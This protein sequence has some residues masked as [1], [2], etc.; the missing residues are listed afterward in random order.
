MV[1]PLRSS[2]WYR[3][4]DLKPR[5]R[6]HARIHRQRHR[7]QLWYVLQDRQNGQFHRLSPL[8]HHIVCLMDGRRTIDQIWEMM[9]ERYG[10]DQPTQDETIRLLAQVHAADLLIGDVPPDM[11][12]LAHRADRHSR[13]SFVQNIRNPLA[14][15]IPLIDPE[16]FLAATAPL[17]RLLFSW[18]GF[19]FWLAT[20]AIGLALAGMRWTALTH[21]V[22]DRVLS[23][24]NIVLLLLVYPLVKALHEIGHGMATARWGGEVHELGVML[25]VLMPVPYVDASAS[26]AF[27]EKRR[28]II[29]G[30]AGIMVEMFLAAVAMMVWALVEKGFV[31]AA[32]FDVMLIG[33]ASTLL[34][35]GNPLLRFDG[36]YIL[37]DL[38]EIPN[39]GA[40]ANAYALYLLQRY[41]F[42]LAHLPSPATSP[43]EARWLL[44]YA[45]ASFL[46]RMTV[47]FGIALFIGSRFF[48]LGILLALW[49]IVTGVA[50]PL[51]KGF[52]RLLTDPQLRSVR[53]R[54][55]LVSGLAT[56]ALVV[57]ATI[58]PV[59]YATMAQGVVVA[60]E[61]STLRVRADG[62]VIDALLAEDLYVE[63]GTRVATLA[64]PTLAGETA[65]LEAQTEAYRL[66][67]EAVAN[68]DLV[69]ANIFREELRRLE[70][71]LAL[72]RR[73]MADLSILAE[74]SGRLIL[75]RA[76]DLP[77]KFLKKGDLLG[78]VIAEGD[79]VVR[80]VVPQSD[81]DLARSRTMKVEIRFVGRVDRVI[82]AVVAREAP[83]ALD[84]L[85]SLALSK[86][87]GGDIA[88]D[89]TKTDAPRALETQFHLDLHVAPQEERMNIGER[90]YVRFD[91]GAEP[92]AW[93]LWR[94]ARQLLLRQFGV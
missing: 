25:L 39:L 38:I 76:S 17:G 66:R 70:G 58:V 73:R 18:W 41:A 2:S 53:G 93:R 91:H 5:L 6:S 34:V 24:E 92:V 27:Q 71:A 51:A 82:P 88:I 4:A 35:N 30:A 89:P 80:V 20:I 37:A 85:P 69:Q 44:A 90:V 31:R 23:S 49:G 63:A 43:G 26:A 45:A 21:N 15:R 59:P 7:G 13:R 48:I 72:N 3:V 22:A 64:D 33:S 56:A 83:A 40:R 68:S 14:I 60:P 32:A 8:A 57:L 28:R 84:E 54:A 81:I 77:G 52:N 61:K 78:Y 65:V 9:G 86:R 29:V 46:Y 94:A 16:R 75:P 42:G 11:E 47:T 67:L 74:N 50:L 10:D 55:I 1:A 87:G 62:E 12:E 79:P 36:Y 19:G